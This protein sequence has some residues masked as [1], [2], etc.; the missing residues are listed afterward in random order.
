VLDDYMRLGCNAARVGRE[1]NHSERTARRLAKQF[2]AYVDKRLT[3]LDEERRIEERT[4]AV[5]TRATQA[6]IGALI[7]GRLWQG[8]APVDGRPAGTRQAGERDHLAR[9]RART[10]DHA[11]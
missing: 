4:R 11:A 8:V 1:T 7:D 10:L 5:Q 3:E 2:A 6:M 9:C